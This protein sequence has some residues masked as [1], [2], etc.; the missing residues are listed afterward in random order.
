[1]RALV[2]RIP[3]PVTPRSAAVP[4]C[5]EYGVPSGPRSDFSSARAVDAEKRSAAT[6]TGTRSAGRAPEKRRR[7]KRVRGLIASCPQIDDFHQADLTEVVLQGGEA[8]VVARER[9]VVLIG[10]RL[11]SHFR[12]R[13]REQVVRVLHDVVATKLLAET[14]RLDAPALRLGEVAHLHVGEA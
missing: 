14:E 9:F 8:R 5:T 11:A 7:T 10:L 13:F 4:D 12:I 6:T 3:S 1:M 2:G